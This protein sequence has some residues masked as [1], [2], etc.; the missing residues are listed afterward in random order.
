MSSKR[1][2]DHRG[3][4]CL[5]CNHPLDITDK[6]CPNC[7][8]K[9]SNKRLTL[10][11]FIE[12]F[13]ANFY[14]YDSKV[15]NTIRS[16]FTKPGQAAKEF[17]AGKRMFYANPFRFYLSI[18]LVYFILLGLINNFSPAD[19]NAYH[20]EN[21]KIKE[22]PID[23]LAQAES[24]KKAEK[25]LDSVL[26]LNAFQDKELGAVFKKKNDTLYT[27]K[28]LAKK[29]AITS[30]YYKIDTYTSFI[31][32]SK[33][34]DYNKILDTLKHDSTNWN[35]F[36]LKKCFQIIEMN[37]SGS[38]SSEKFFNYFIDKLTFI[39]F[40]SLPFLTFN[41]ALLYY[42]SKLNY[43]EHLVFVFSVMSF[44]FLILFLFEFLNL[45]TAIKLDGFIFLGLY[46]YFYKALR[47]FYG[48]SR[49]KTIIKFVLLNFM[50]SITAVFVG[51][52]MLLFVFI[53]Y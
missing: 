27:E 32:K 28:Q 45:F 38:T 20:F 46:F 25:E 37:T 21:E 51:L 19:D 49:L 50:L 2:K 48:Q 16:L 7:S 43:A 40:I 39:L 30:L 31:E 29:N 9:N 24:E 44:V 35:K 34:T 4:S 5:N 3:N 41:F 52:L 1:L 18:S 13:L 15:K 36:L 22:T 23:S 42:R 11:D 33:E 17:I 53:L 14:A 26:K 6:Y 10:K 8:Q 47:N 12:E